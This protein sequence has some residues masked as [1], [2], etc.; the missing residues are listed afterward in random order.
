MNPEFGDNSMQVYDPR[1]NKLE[2]LAQRRG[3]LDVSLKVGFD[4]VRCPSQDKKV[5]GRS[6]MLYP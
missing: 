1:L 4:G 5:S 3:T 6:D 2:K